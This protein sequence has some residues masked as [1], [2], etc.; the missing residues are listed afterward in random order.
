MA[1]PGEHGSGPAVA[2]LFQRLLALNLL[3]AWLSL[4]SQV[5]LLYGSRGLLPISELM[6]HARRSDELG[7]SDLPTHFWFGAEDPVLIGTCWLGAV[8]AAVALCVPRPPW[9]H[10]GLGVSTALYLGFAA[11]GRDFLGFQWDSLLVECGVLAVLLRTTDAARGRGPGSGRWVHLLLRVVLFKVFW[12]SGLAKWQSSAGDWTSGVAMAQYYETAPLP[13][14]LGWHAHHLP[15]AWH[16]FESWWTLF[17]ELIVPFGIF[18]PRWSRR[19][20]LLIF[21]AFVLVDGATA[22]YGFFLP[23]TVALMA[24]LLDDRDVLSAVEVLR[25]RTGWKLRH[26]PGAGAE[27]H[28]SK[29]HAGIMVPVSALLLGLSLQAGLARF[30]DIDPWPTLRQAARPLRVAN[31]YHLFGSITTTRDEATFMVQDSDGAWVELE[32][33]H[34]PGAADRR[35]GFVAPHQPRV[36]FQLWF[37]GLRW[38]RGAPAWMP[39]LL[40]RICHEPEV[41]QQLFRTTLPTDAEAIELVFYDQRFTSP[42]QKAETGDW[43][44]RTEVGRSGVVPCEATRR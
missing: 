37:Y 6:A 19:G 25:R 26:W 44:T 18:G 17:F 15:R 24:M 33:H 21:G 34:K 28:S 12:E 2:W 22:N 38:K 40:S 14:W 5:E 10:L 35:P 41:V 8:L 9:P 1:P 23:L 4:H 3:V 42:E 20:V 11:A 7:L 13:T 43:W 30:A 16:T 32:L 27:E 39:V 29:V 31:T 36:D